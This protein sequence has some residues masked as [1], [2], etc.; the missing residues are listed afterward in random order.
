M[1][2]GDRISQIAQNILFPLVNIGDSNLP[3]KGIKVYKAR[4]GLKCIYRNR[5]LDKMVIWEQ[6]KWKEYDNLKIQPNSIVLEIGAHIGTSTLEYA[7]RASQGMIYAVEALPENYNILK[8]NIALNGFKNIKAYQLAI[9]GD[10]SKKSVDLH[11]NPYNSG[12]HSL[13]GDTMP[14]NEKIQVPAKTLDQFITELGIK[15]I[16]A[17]HIDVEGAEY[18]ILFNTPK[19][20]LSSIPQIILEYHDKLQSKYKFHQLLEYFHNLGYKTEIYHSNISKL[21]N[22]E[23]GIISAIKTISDS[24]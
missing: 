14:Q 13:Y 12:G 9:V 6:W 2:L 10:K 8:Q 21:L 17:L 18:E 24:I 20:I 7:A 11:Y 23:T 1:T 19:K 16:D 15:R 3:Q 4:D 5:S 22:L